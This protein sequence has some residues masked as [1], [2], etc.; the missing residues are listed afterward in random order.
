MRKPSASHAPYGQK[1]PPPRRETAGGEGVSCRN[2]KPW[3][4]GAR[5][6][7]PDGS[8]DVGRADEAE[9]AEG[10]VEND[11]ANARL[12]DRCLGIPG[13]LNE[14]WFAEYVQH[15]HGP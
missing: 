11:V 4:I 9:R 5:S 15:G 6:Y 12:A 2:A 8:A 3:P 13:D 1:K 10:S 7:G 14:I